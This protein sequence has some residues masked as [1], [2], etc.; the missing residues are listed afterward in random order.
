[1]TDPERL[2]FATRHFRDLQTI[3]FAPVPLAMI[4]TL[5]M[6]APTRLSP[7]TLRISLA[8]FLLIAVAFFWWSTVAIRRRYGSVK[9][10]REERRRMNLHPAIVALT[11]TASTLLPVRRHFFP[12]EHWSEYS[13][14]LCVVL[15][16]LMKILDSTNLP[17]RRI[18][19]AVGLV[20]LLAL[21]P[22]L[23]NVGSP[24]ALFALAGAVW[25]ALST[26]DFLL[27]RR[28]L[29]P[30]SQS[31]MDAVLRHG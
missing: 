7:I 8:V 23:E 22:L 26:Y 24:A 15:L 17:H 16:L 4:L 31:A 2:A 28:I 10:S 25:L 9:V 29:A 12:R 6:P 5:A 11:L 3:R 18:A 14:D 13:L 19:W 20:T 30:P 27:L 1:M 21:V